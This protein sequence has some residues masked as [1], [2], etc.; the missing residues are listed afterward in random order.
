MYTETSLE[1]SGLCFTCNNGSICVL[2]EKRGFDA[3]YCET[4][5]INASNGHG[6]IAQFVDEVKPL[7]KKA[8]SKFLGLCS[9]CE[10]CE[11]CHL[12][13]PDGGVWHCEEYC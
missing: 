8:D 4:F 9:N 11:S 6:R 3:Y 10:N 13:K 2:R 12:P 5:D 1:K 7:A